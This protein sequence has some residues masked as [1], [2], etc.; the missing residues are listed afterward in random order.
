[1][2]YCRIFGLDLSSLQSEEHISC[3]GCDGNA[4]VRAVVG[5]GEAVGWRPASRRRIL[6]LLQH[7]ARRGRWPRN[8]DV[9]ARMRDGQGWRA[10][11]LHHGNEAPEAARQRIT[12]TTQARSGIRLADGAADRI[13]AVGAGA[14]AAGD[15]VPVNGVALPK[16][17]RAEG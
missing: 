15:F 5:N 10:D 16:S 4:L 11:G 8:N 2:N 17:P 3:P 12:A 7:K 9:V 1:M 14:A 6:I 13:P